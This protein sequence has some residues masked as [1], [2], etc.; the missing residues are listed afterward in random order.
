MAL[1][2]TG[3]DFRVS[4]R[5]YFDPHIHE[6][7]LFRIFRSCWLFVAHESEVPEP[8]DYVTRRLG[9]DPV[10]VVRDETGRIRV[11]LN[12]C[13]HRGVPLCRS[14]QGNASHFR[15]SYHGWTYAN[16]GE[17]RGVTFQREVYGKDFDR[18]RYGLY[19]A[20]QVDTAYGLV[21]ATWDRDVPAL[22]D[23][24]GDTSY[25]L[26]TIFGKF[27][28]GFTVAGAPVRTLITTNW[29]AESENL[30]GDGYHTPI[31]HQTAFEFGLF[32]KADSFAKYGEVIA[33][34]F[35][36]RT[37][38]CGNGHTVRVQHLPIRPERPMFFGYPERLWPQVERNLTAGQ[39][40]VQNR[41]S[42]MHGTIFPNLSFLENLKTGTDGPGSMSRFIRVTLKVPLAADLT[43]VVWW[44]LV[45]V[46]T[47]ARWRE[48]SQRAYA[49]TNGPGGMFEVDDNENYIGMA[50]AH[51]GNVAPDGVYELIAGRGH[52]RAAGL[53]WPG[54][55]MDA[56]RTEHTIRAF[57]TR[58]HALMEP[59]A[60]GG[61]RDG[62]A[63]GGAFGQ[64]PGGEV[65]GGEV[66]GGAAAEGVATS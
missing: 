1:I 62:I 63:G 54:D 18:S 24:L 42:V 50:E 66:P 44:H 57:L 20:A 49:R 29:K 13:R 19:R 7:E 65:P 39:V 47:G 52:D 16:T 48:H 23:Y 9:V 41:L 12:S 25:Y 30:S 43:E 46:E 38:D 64:A 34:R 61:V 26:E 36:G 14:D 51:A 60:N 15:C 56:D 37:V 53:E 17:L 55:V 21:F 28:R 4:R 11:L 5:V 59:E 22:P 6:R 58:W 32:P 2:D 10:I 3:G 45:P 27:D 8:G 31:T 40:D 35:P 33:P